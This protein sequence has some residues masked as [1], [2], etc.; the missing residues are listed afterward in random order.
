MISTRVMDF[1]L[2]EAAE[3]LGEDST[4]KKKSKFKTFKKFFGKKKRKESPSSTGSSTWKQSQAKSEVMAIESGP[5][6]YDSEDELE[7][8]RGSLG[9]RALSHDSIFIPESCQDPPRPVRV[10]SQENVCDRIKALQLKIQC[11]VKVGPPPPGGLPAKR[12]DDAG[13]SS[14]DDGLPRSP[15]EMSLL[16]DIGPSTTIKVSLISSSRPP[17]PDQLS[18]R[19]LSDTPIFSRTL[20]SS[21][22]PVAD[23]SYPPEF[24]SCLDNS[25]AKHKLLVKP[26]NQ[27][28]SKMRRLSSRAQSECLSDLIC[29]PEEE[30]YD[31]KPSPTV[32]S[33]DKPTTGQ[34]DMVQDRGPEP[35]KPATMLPPGGPR[36]RRARL[37]HCPALSASAE[38]ESAPGDNPSSRPTTPE[39]TEPVS[40]PAPCLE[41]PLLPEDSLHPDPDSENQREELSFASACPPA[42][43]TADEVACASGDAESRLS[44]HIPGEDMT[45][46]ATGPAT[47]VETPSGPEGP[48]H[49]V[50]KEVELTLAVPSLEGAGTEC[51]ETPAPNLPVPKSCL[52]HKALV[53][54]R[55]LN[56]SLALST[57]ESPPEEP[58][59][60]ALDKD[61]SPLEPSRAE[62]A[63]SPQEGPE[64]VAREQKIARGGGEPRSVKKFSVS[65]GR[66]WPRTGHRDRLGH[67]GLVGPAAVPSAVRLP[68]LRSGQAWQSEAALDD[69]QVPPVPQ[70]RKLDPQEPPSPAECGSQDLGDRVASQA[71]PG[72]SPQ[73]AVNTPAT[74]DPCPAAQEPPT[75]G[76]RSSFPVK[77]RSTSLSFKHR[78]VSSP[79]VKGIKRYSAEVRLEKGGLTLLSKEDKCPMR[80]APATRGA[81]S[82]NDQ[83]KG[84]VRSSEQLGSKPPLPRKPLLQALTLPYPPA[85]PDVSPG[86]L[87]K[88]TLP[89]GPRKES[90]M[91]EK[92]SPHQG[93]DKGLPP[94]ATGPGAEGQSGP[95]WITITRQKRRGAPEQPP[96]QQDKPGAQTQKS[97]TGKQAKVPERAQEPMKQA[98]FVRSKSFLMAPAKPAVER[99]QGAKLCLQ[100]GL[101]RGIS[102]SHQ[103][104]AAQSAVMTEK[105]LHQLK[106]ASYAS[107]EQPSW[108]ELARKKSQAWSDMPQI[109]K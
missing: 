64:R 96:N 10:F 20:D 17:S 87:D 71:G 22:A 30:E 41:S 33:E 53:A 68:L 24:S 4:G 100:E 92:R 97:E 15:P 80:T 67:S 52:K 16:H 82:P 75:G 35:G 45:P 5:V 63:G 65:S 42:G 88:A 1:K 109:I 70:N 13:M 106:R 3:G 36:A 29:T 44:P 43:D 91:A 11:N 39:V 86:E 2:R 81:R 12:G 94:S 85:S 78:D 58:T 90:R 40:S 18:S 57:S 73:D 84:K 103:N 34:Q 26:R 38:E 25:A 37:Q 72:R 56:V 93:A 83:G 61:A 46:P 47:T 89:P 7:E 32:I 62:L 50:Q 77:L 105:E 60:C 54:S 98:D 55:S 31:E 19:H 101:Q 28:S 51:S 9:S 66:A 107:A 79:E 8:S 21:V 69:L 14:E 102:L 104:L 6:G 48:D 74:S 99:R 108:M 76:D 23:F 95:P 59:P 27:R 49:N